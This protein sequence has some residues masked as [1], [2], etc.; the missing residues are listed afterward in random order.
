[1][2][3]AAAMGVLMAG[4][5]GSAD[6]QS[7]P[8]KLDFELGSMR[9][10][11]NDVRIRGDAGTKFDFRDLTGSSLNTVRFDLTWERETGPGYRFLYAPL[12]ASGTGFLDSAVNFNGQNF[13][14]GVATEGRY[15]FNSYRATWRNRWKQGPNS[16]WRV[17]F[18]LKVRDA[19]VRV[20]QGGVT[21]SDKNVGLVP[22]LH[23]YGEER[24]SDRWRFTFDF[25]GL[26]APQGR[27]FDFSGRLGYLV[28]PGS[29]V[30]LG[31]RVLEGGVD[32]ERVFN[33]FL[34]SSVV[35]GWSGRF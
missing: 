7:G 8:W 18:T 32:N 3:I 13:A 29:E 20:S 16:D 19:E 17:G 1:M 12:V 35:L 34:Q 30:Y 9:V 2:K 10:G 28:S 14:A 33:F 4:C 5:L 21:E 25:D 11:L 24:L 27:A 22:L 26:A 23:I 31:L 6:S 15:Q